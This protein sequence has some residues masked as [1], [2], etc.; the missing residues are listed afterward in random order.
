MQEITLNVR[1]ANQ[2]KSLRDPANP[3][4]I[5]I[6]AFIPFSE[7]AKLDPGNANVR[8]ASRKRPFRLMLNTVEH[9]PNSF[10]LKNRGITYLCQAAEYLKDSK[11]L[12]VRIPQATNGVNGFKFGIAD[13]GHT[14]EVI[15]HTVDH[16]EKYKGKEGWSEPYVKIHIVTAENESLNQVEDIVE[17]LNTS[18]QVQQYTLNEYKHKFDALKQSLK[19]VGFPLEL[20]AFTENQNKP[21]NVVEII[22]RLTV[23]LKDRWIKNEPSSV[24]KSK[25]KALNYFETEDGQR[26]FK[27]LDKVLKDI[28]SFPEFIEAEFSKQELIEGKNVWKLKPVKKL[29]KEWSR[30]GTP[31]I[32]EYKFDLAALLPM[33]AAFRELLYTDNEGYYQWKANPFE[34]FTQVAK[35]LYE[36]LAKRSARAKTASQLGSDVA[37]WS[38]CA[39]IVANAGNVKAA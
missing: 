33:A 5:H 20:I 11:S 19:N 28:L 39:A 17:S 23:F 37:Y 30:P 24:Y 18:T 3:N 4:I 36:T 16:I 10:H 29:E 38:L 14:F 15:K 6:E 13:G 22:Q 32:T 12:T 35:D 8:P 1:E 25:G 9:S 21:W 7:A 34:V 26:E 27:K 31:Y 2:V